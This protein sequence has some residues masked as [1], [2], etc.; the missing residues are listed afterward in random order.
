MAGYS[1][2]YGYANYLG[3]WANDA[4]A[5]IELRARKWDSTA[6]GLGNPRNGMTYYATGTHTYRGYQG[7]AWTDFVTP[8]VCTLDFAYDAG[9]AGLGRSI[10]AD[11]GA[12]DISV[13]L[14]VNGTALAIHQLNPAAT[15]DVFTI[16]NLGASGASI[17]LTGTRRFIETDSDDATFALVANDANAYVLHLSATN[18]GAGTAAIGI[19]ADNDIDIVSTAGRLTLNGYSS[20]GIGVEIEATAGGGS[21]NICAVNLPNA[22]NIGTA[23]AR[24]ISVGHTAATS[25]QLVSL[26][27]MLQVNAND[28]FART[29]TISAANAGAGAA[30][31]D[32]DAKS[33]IDILAGT[34]FSIDGTGASNV[35]ATSGNLTISTITSGTLFL[36]SAGAW[37]AQ[38]SD[39]T[40]LSMAANSGGDKTLTI[41]ATNVGGGAAFLA[42]S[43]GYK[44]G[45][46]FA[47]DLVLSA[48][49]AEWSLFE[50]NFG[51]VSLLNA[52]NQCAALAVVTLDEA[53]NAGVAS[54]AVDA[55]DVTWTTTGA[56]SH[57]FNLAGCTGVADGFFIE[58]GTDYWRLTHTRANLMNLSTE[59][60]SAVI[61]TA[62]TFDLNA[63]GAVTIDSS[64]DGISL[65]GILSSN[66]TVTGNSVGNQTLTVQVSNA[67]AG[68]GVLD[69]LGDIAH[70]YGDGAGGGAYVRATN[71]AP[72]E[73]YTNVP[74]SDGTYI[75]IDAKTYLSAT[76]GSYMDL[77]CAGALQLNSSGGAIGIGNDAAAF[78]IN[79]GTGAA[80]RVVTIGNTTGATAV[81]VNTG[82][83]DFA[84]NTNQ[85]YVDQ[86]TG[87]VGIGTATPA[88]RLN[89]QS[90]AIRFDYVPTISCAGVTWA[91]GGAGVNTPGDHTMKVTAVNAFGETELGTV[92]PNYTV[93][94][95]GEA[96]VASNIPVSPDPTVTSR[97]V[98]ITKFGPGAI[99]YLVAGLLPDNTTT[100]CTINVA[101]A[102]LATPGPSQNR[103]SGYL[104]AGTT[105]V[106]NVDGDGNYVLGGTSTS[107][108]SGCGTI[109]CGSTGTLFRNNANT[110]TYGQIT[111]SSGFWGIGA[112]ATASVTQLL[113]LEGN[114]A[115]RQIFMTRRS[116]ADTDGNTLSLVCGGA[117]I[118]A[119]NKNG[120][121]LLLY[122]G[123]ST[124][125][126]T[127]KI[128]GYIY[129]GIAAATTDN[130][131]VDWFRVSSTGFYIGPTTT[132]ASAYLHVKGGTATAGTAS[133]KISTCASLLTA[134]ETG[135]VEKSANTFW[136]GLGTDAGDKARQSFDGTLY[137]QVT[138]KTV[139]NTASET[140]LVDT[141][142]ARQLPILP[143]EFFT[144]GKT[145]RVNARGYYN[146]D[147]ATTLNL[148]IKLNKGGTVYTMCATG[149]MALLASQ[150]KQEWSLHADLV[151]NTAGGAGTLTCFG[152]VIVWNTDTVTHETWECYNP[153]G[154]DAT[155]VVDTR[156]DLTF[157]LT[158]DFS[159]AAAGINITCTQLYLETID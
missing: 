17:A 89:I 60:G 117:T 115:A 124:G 36:N 145:L 135:A 80:A 86:P 40:T 119:T 37:S 44:A 1:T 132:A 92:S 137:S 106:F 123:V 107:T 41:S 141:T 22:L 91:A 111:Q 4:A 85:L 83:G 95:A 75:R 78:A 96:W 35:S 26:Q 102:A 32:I 113:T 128:I 27:T 134:V 112:V 147:N 116:T 61:G 138:W 24:T 28:A 154:I 77:D 82:S 99:W 100:T 42:F 148:R 73:I 64:A 23:G 12:V 66:F 153:A 125:A 52:I 18:T 158:E 109:C 144:A 133:F 143:D 46:T 6:D 62:T 118:G 21:V 53:Y 84:V 159:G 127:S 43:D 39:T 30:H 11:S 74:G 114:A 79:I 34:T 67:G 31:I 157:N 51:E 151:C 16:E 76:A 90:G 152:E 48:L 13:P 19:G 94:G 101:D 97:N 47:S 71:G 131:A 3:E 20:A 121:D 140:T 7:G 54:I 25:L 110:A 136:G 9:G 63:T 10:T 49:D 59:L 93:T 33:T 98:Y 69:L 108:L 130:T 146:T 65:D 150:T 8:G 126:G 142:G 81:A 155:V 129:P 15:A 58:D 104:Y 88:Q 29:L 2:P 56:Y 149:D 70:L 105:R 72:V 68:L 14:A 122:S 55:Y 45:S 57:V 38:G 5:L 103:T 156:D 50:T 120:G 139:S 87:F